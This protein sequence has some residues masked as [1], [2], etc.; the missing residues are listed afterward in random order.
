M[1]GALNRMLKCLPR[2]GH[3]LVSRAATGYE[4]GRFQGWRIQ[5]QWGCFPHLFQALCNVV[6][7][8]SHL[9]LRLLPEFKHQRTPGRGIIARVTLEEPRNPQ[10]SGNVGDIRIVSDDDKNPIPDLT[11]RSGD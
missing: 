5:G 11:Q 10:Q 2:A 8:D 6:S 4:D 3:L 9:S 7:V 1:D